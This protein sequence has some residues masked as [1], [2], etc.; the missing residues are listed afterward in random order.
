MNP[1][2]TRQLKRTSEP[3]GTPEISLSRLPHPAKAS[4]C[5]ISLAQSHHSLHNNIYMSISAQHVLNSQTFHYKYCVTSVI[6]VTL[7][8]HG[9][10]D[11]W[12]SFKFDKYKNDGSKMPMLFPK[13]WSCISRCGLLYSSSIIFDRGAHYLLWYLLFAMSLEFIF[14]AAIVMMPQRNTKTRV[15]QTEHY[16]HYDDNATVISDANTS[17]SE[18]GMWQIN[19][20]IMENSS[21]LS[22]TVILSPPSQP[23]QQQLLQNLMTHSRTNIKTK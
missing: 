12:V 7:T 6:L 4:A 10:R 17:V 20:E 14:E 1:L 18:P 23:L 2:F 19:M 8:T 15:N 3:H 21:K 9:C 13:E 22:N 5:Q 11:L 16:R